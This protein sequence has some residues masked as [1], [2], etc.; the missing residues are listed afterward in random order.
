MGQRYWAPLIDFM[1][2]R[3]V[4]ER[5]ID[6][7]DAQRIMVTDSAEEAVE[8]VTEAGLRQFGLTYRQGMKRRRMFW[9]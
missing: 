9:E 8:A 5:T 6:P 4:T 2:E 3:L 1:R 7:I